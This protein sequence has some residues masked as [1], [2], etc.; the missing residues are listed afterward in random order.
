MT[1]AAK[2]TL[3]WTPRVLCI[4]FAVFL[5]LFALDVFG[6]EL[7]FWRTIGGFLV[8]LLPVFLLLAILAAS[9]P[10][11]WIGALLFAGLGI[12]YD[13]TFGRH[14]P[15]QTKAIISGPLF[16]IALLFLAN[17][18]KRAELHARS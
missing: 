1:S 5:S 9:W 11:E 6:E 17:W 18:L 8:H 3:Y 2:R 16:T 12:L 10:W 7:G 15:W 14:F 13:V 4:V